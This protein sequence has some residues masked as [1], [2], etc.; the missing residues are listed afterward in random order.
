MPTVCFCLLGLSLAW[1][2]HVSVFFISLAY[3]PFICMA[4]KNIRSE[5]N[6][7]A[8]GNYVI[9]LFTTLVAIFNVFILI[10]MENFVSILNFY[11]E[12]NVRVLI[13]N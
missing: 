7:C 5:S 13:S 12:Y 11:N 10:K 1:R 9:F 4:N 2:M 3:M 6:S 8:R